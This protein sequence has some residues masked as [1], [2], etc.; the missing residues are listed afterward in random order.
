MDGG[1]VK[2]NEIH[3][4]WSS[5]ALSTQ[6]L[7]FPIPTCF[8]LCFKTIKVFYRSISG[9]KKQLFAINLSRICSLK[10]L[11]TIAPSSISSP[12]LSAQIP[13]IYAD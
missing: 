5:R 10:S 2:N 7:I 4:F 11:T 12:K 8:K 1:D 6:Q 13:E 9:L 3:N